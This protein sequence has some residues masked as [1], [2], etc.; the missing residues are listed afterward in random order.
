M[1]KI[2]QSSV[3]PNELA[4]TI[5]GLL[6][7]LVPILMLL[8]GLNHISVGQDQVSG[9]IDALSNIVIGIGSVVSSVMVAWGLIRKLLVEIG[10]IK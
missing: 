6:V 1:Y 5:K 10:L 2:F 3:D 7:G 4:L 9:I 8:V